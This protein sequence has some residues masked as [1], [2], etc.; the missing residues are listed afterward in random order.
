MDGW[1]D[2]WL[3]LVAHAYGR[4]RSVGFPTY[5]PITRSTS[6]RTYKTHIISPQQPTTNNR[7]NM[8]NRTLLF[9]VYPPLIRNG[10]GYSAANHGTQQFKAEGNSDPRTHTTWCLQPTFF[11]SYFL[12]NSHA[13]RLSFHHGI[14]KTQVLEESTDST[15]GMNNYVL[16]SP[17]KYGMVKECSNA[18]Y[19][20]VWAMSEHRCPRASW[21]IPLV[22]SFL[23]CYI[24]RCP[25][26]SPGSRVA[27]RSIRPCMHVESSY[28]G[29]IYH[30]SSGL[31]KSI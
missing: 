4:T 30:S 10:Q 22:H 6:N 28:E 26:E 20:A 8:F 14:F 7:N 17:K 18:L 23:C 16:W 21:A 11:I 31:V 29:L 9:P 15:G 5:L 13:V 2:G 19:P 25:P 27:C 3:Y 24:F 12:S 1:M